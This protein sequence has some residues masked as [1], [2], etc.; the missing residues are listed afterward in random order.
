MARRRLLALL[1]AVLAGAG[2]TAAAVA[3]ASP[4]PRSALRPRQ[5][6]AAVHVSLPVDRYPASVT[7]RW[8][9]ITTIGGRPAMW[10]AAR[11]GVTLVRMNQRLVHLALHAGSADP[12]G[13][14]WRYGDVIGGL[15][16]H[17]LILGFNG[18]FK[19]PTGSGGF[20][21]FGR[22]GVPLK[23]GYGSVVTYA[24]GTTQIGAWRAGVPARGVAI[25]SVR[26]NL[27]LLIDHGVPNGS[28]DNCGAPCWGATVGNQ[29]A[30]A[31]S[32][33]G[34]RADG[35]LVWAAGEGLTVHR[36]AAGRR[37]A[38]RG[39]NAR[40][41][42]T[43]T[44]DGWPDTCTSITG[45]H[46]SPR[47]RLSPA[48]TESRGICWCPTAGTSSPSYRTD[49]SSGHMSHSARPDRYRRCLLPPGLRRGG[50]RRKRDVPPTGRPARPSSMR[51]PS[52]TGPVRASAAC[53]SQVR[54]G[55]SAS[56]HP[57]RGWCGSSSGTPG[58]SWHFAFSSHGTAQ[59][60]ATQRR[61]ERACH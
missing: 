34:I 7:A 22:V 61:L 37:P 58:R 40:S 17:H 57:T 36:L 56:G 9:V 30:V 8:Q 6:P 43:S 44:R 29:A 33:L 27:F 49:R 39:S 42:S 55:S 3:S 53:T 38:P 59:G 54:P 12:G 52:R 23:A 2:V 14:G 46:R 47:C 15:E 10:I 45:P 21:S 11:Q 35:Q 26:Q 25:A 16:L 51:S 48:S 31:R 18:G 13:T 60:T 41:S 5:H 4:V 28:V 32:G 20:L 19:F 24:N 1:V 50:R